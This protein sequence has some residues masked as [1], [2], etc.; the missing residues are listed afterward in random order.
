MKQAI[1]VAVMFFTT[2]SAFAAP[3]PVEDVAG[4]SNNDRVSR[5]ERIIKAKQQGEFDMQ[6]RMDSLQN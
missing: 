3:A 2:A 4:G 5:L 6:R 1:L